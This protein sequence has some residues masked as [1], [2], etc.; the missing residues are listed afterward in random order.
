[1]SQP[2]RASTHLDQ[3]LTDFSLAQFQSESVFRAA[4][5][6]PTKTVT[7][8]SN[9][10]FVY[11]KD[12]FAR[13]DVQLRAAGTE[14]NGTGFK[15]SNDSYY[16]DKYSLH[17][18]LSYDEISEA[19]S[20]L[21]LE[22][23]AAF[24]IAQQML[25][26]RE[27]LVAGATFKTGVWGLDVDGASTTK[28]SDYVASDPIATIDSAAKAI[29]LGSFNNPSTLILGL[30]VFNALKSHPDLNRTLNVTGPQ[31]E[32]GIAR[33]LGVS[34]IIVPRAIGITGN[35]D[36]TGTPGFI[37][38]PKCALLLS[39]P[40]SV[41]LRSPAAGM[42]FAW[43]GAADAPR[44]NGVVSRRLEMPSTQSV[45][46]ESDMTLDVKITGPSMGV[47]FNNIVA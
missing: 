28:W 23:D 2:N 36:K 3:I 24:L 18:D 32:A 15:L 30:D 47:F 16:C 37:W 33:Q 17:V 29:L 5:I 1:M 8:Q 27:R 40:T 44:P 14:S 43:T 6:L 46:I 21:N 39:N 12:A 45:R 41:G 11:D 22:Q 38:N 31:D 25:Q 19:D 26:K 13:D 9:K 20:P 4:D 34:R 42:M 7:K 35:E 10:Y